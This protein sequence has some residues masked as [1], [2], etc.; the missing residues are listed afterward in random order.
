MLHFPPKCRKGK[1]EKILDPLSLWNK[2]ENRQSSRVLKPC[3]FAAQMLIAVSCWALKPNTGIIYHLLHGQ[4]RTLAE[5]NLSFPW[6]QV[7]RFLPNLQKKSLR[8]LFIGF[9][10]I[11]REQGEVPQFPKGHIFPFQLWKQL[12]Q[13]YTH[14]KNQKVCV[15]TRY[16]PQRLIRLKHR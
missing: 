15:G 16:Y 1:F 7:K 10:S 5:D 13:L 8:V 3:N 11:F 4:V 12:F 6:L 2:E 9:F 14:A